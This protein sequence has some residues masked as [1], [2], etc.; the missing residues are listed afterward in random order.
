MTKTAE[1][2][3]M[4]SDCTVKSNQ[5]QQVLVLVLARGGLTQL[6]RELL[7]Q[8]GHGGADAL[9]DGGGEGGADGQPVD[10]VVQPVAQR[11]HPGQSA[12]VRVGGSFQPIAG[13]AA[14]PGAGG[15]V[16]TLGLLQRREEEESFIWTAFE[17]KA[18][19]K[20]GRPA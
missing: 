9:E 2:T 17:E 15:G 20:R 13:A 5:Q 3:E 10:E 14:P 19:L 12:D 8:D 16:R 7:T 6:V 18:S 11:D 1:S 4:Q